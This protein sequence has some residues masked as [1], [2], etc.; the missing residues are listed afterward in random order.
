MSETFETQNSEL[1]K[2]IEELLEATKGDN[3][4]NTSCEIII[5]LEYGLK[6]ANTK[7][8]AF[9]SGEKY[10]CHY[11]FNSINK[12]RICVEKILGIRKCYVYG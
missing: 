1:I 8:M 4:M 12:L 11:I 3:C 7:V 6:A 5:T 2:L 9:E 10:I